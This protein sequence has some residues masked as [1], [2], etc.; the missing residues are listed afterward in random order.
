M[1]NLLVG[2]LSVENVYSKIC[3]LGFGLPSRLRTEAKNPHCLYLMWE[4]AVGP[5][6]GYRVYCFPADSQKAEIIKDIHDGDLDKAVI[7]GLKPE[8]EYRVGITSVSSGI[9]SNIVFS[10][11]QI[12]MRKCRTV[13]RN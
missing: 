10:E 2:Y 7:S 6:T 1:K 11:G 9:E 5:V 12:K 13:K 4:K 3:F 8:T